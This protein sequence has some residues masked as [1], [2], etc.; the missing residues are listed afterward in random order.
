MKG[1]TLDTCMSYY[2]YE[3]HSIYQLSQLYDRPKIQY[4]KVIT[5]MSGQT[6]NMSVFTIMKGP[7]GKP[8]R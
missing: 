1:Q 8:I 7:R 4:M 3:G 2:D 6:F 5:I